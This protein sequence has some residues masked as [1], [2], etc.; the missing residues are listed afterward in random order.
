M[1][2]PALQVWVSRHTAQVLPPRPHDW[3]EVAETRSE[4]QVP[5]ERQPV[6]F[7]A[8]VPHEEATAAKSNVRRRERSMSAVYTLR[9]PFVAREVHEAELG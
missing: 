6:H 4:T 1:H 7:G 5:F 3:G 9:V 8:G 2:A